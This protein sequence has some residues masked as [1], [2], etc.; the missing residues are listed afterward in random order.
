MKSSRKHWDTIFSDTEDSKLGW[1]EKNAFPTLELLNQVPEWKKSTVFLPGV[2]TS[3]LIEE[4]LSTGVKLILNDISL[5]ALNRVRVRL[6]NEGRE[7]DWLCQDIARPIQGTIP[8]VDIWIDRAVLHFLTDEDDI[9]GYFENVKSTL[10]AGGYAIFAEFSTTGAPECAGLTLHRYS[11]EALSEKLGSL[12][13]LVS[14]FDYTYI[15]PSGD[16]RPY[17]YALYKREK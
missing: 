16:P 4:L 15:N 13:K 2:G 9:K 10:N 11:I 8:D 17:I 14:H 1:Y 7:I 12:F 3:V 6:N 5:E